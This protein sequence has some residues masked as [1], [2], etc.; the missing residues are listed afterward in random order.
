M[1]GV[2]PDTRQARDSRDGSIDAGVARDLSEM[3]RDLEA[4]PDTAAVMR[5]IV[6]AAVDEVH[7]CVGSAITLLQRGVVS[8]PAHSDEIAGRVDLAQQHTGEGPCVDTSRQEVTLRS[9]DLRDDARWPRWAAVAVEN[10]VL[11]VLSFQLFVEGDTMGAL[12]VYGD[13]PHAFDREAE[14]TGLLLASHAAIALAGSRKINNLRIA[15]DSRDVIG[16]AKG[17]LMERHKISAG[18]AFD[19]LVDVSQRSHRKLR[20]VAQELAETGELITPSG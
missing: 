11:S 4:E 8:S 12:D 6:R 19:R 10:G 17:I 13:R 3:A 16:Q 15:A 5:R 18:Q 7:G 2:D 9:D 20:E 14:N 1:T